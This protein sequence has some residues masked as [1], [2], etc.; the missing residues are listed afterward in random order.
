MIYLLTGT[1]GSGKTLAAM[2][3]IEQWG[4]EKAGRLI[5][6]A[7]IDGQCYPGVL[8]LDD[9]GVLEWH[10]HCEK[11]S[12]VVVDEAQ[13]YWRASRGGD[14]SQAIIE[15]ETHRHDGIDIVLMTQHP[16]F[17][18]ANIR[19]LVNVHIHLVAHTKA[20][21]LRYEWREAHDDVQDSALRMLGEFKEWKYPAH[22][23]PFYKSATM[24]TKRPSA[25][26]R[27]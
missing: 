15:M 10:K 13:R 14:P 7:N 9:A 23:Y 12:L 26:G 25:R 2:E 11:D 24:H 19:K 5:Y 22:L 3:L 20:S 8:P 27:R 18:H 4:K 1:P 6:S 16:T 17:L 21:A